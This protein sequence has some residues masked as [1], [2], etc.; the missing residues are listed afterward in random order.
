MQ[1]EKNIEKIKESFTEAEACRGYGG[2]PAFSLPSGN[3]G[4]II[5]PENKTVWKESDPIMPS[6]DYIFY[7]FLDTLTAHLVLVAFLLA[8]TDEKAVWQRL[9]KLPFVCPMVT[10]A[11]VLPSGETAA[12][13]A[14][15]EDRLI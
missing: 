2:L 10:T 1:D 11:T 4:A 12:S 5:S 6:L 7:G 14:K 8:V 9:K 13:T 3:R 15:V